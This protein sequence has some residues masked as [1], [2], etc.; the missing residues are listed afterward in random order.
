[1]T[2]TYTADDIRNAWDAADRADNE[3]GQA[4]YRLTVM[5]FRALVQ[6]A[7]HKVTA[8]SLVTETRNDDTVARYAMTGR[9][10]AMPGE[11]DTPEGQ[12][13]EA[14]YVRGLVNAAATRKG[15]GLK[16]IKTA[17]RGVDDRADAVKILK[18]LIKSKPER[19]EDE[20][21]DT[22]L[23]ML[24]RAITQVRAA[25]E[26]VEMTPEQTAR[27]IAAATDTMALAGQVATVGEAV[28]A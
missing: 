23:G 18:D 27:L 25:M 8:K 4:L 11:V 21:M 17:L 6:K 20:K 15:V 13:S 2:T 3:A 9:I 12:T 24:E 7:P 1:M 19:T 10:L 28:A 26:N 22:A 16:T 14:H 5:I